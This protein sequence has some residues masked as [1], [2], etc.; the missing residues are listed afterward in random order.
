[1]YFGKDLNPLSIIPGLYNT[2]FS[3]GQSCRN[4]VL[5]IWRFRGH[6][7]KKYCRLR[8]SVMRNR[9]TVDVSIHFVNIRWA[10]NRDNISRLTVSVKNAM[11]TG[12]IIRVSLIFDWINFAQLRFVRVHSTYSYYYSGE[13]CAEIPT[14]LRIWCVYFRTLRVEVKR[15]RW[16]VDI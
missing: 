14:E 10:R 13:K 9:P 8:S 1:M 3:V 16:S 11:F 7:E 4:S 5:R 6:R 12:I 2:M 15:P